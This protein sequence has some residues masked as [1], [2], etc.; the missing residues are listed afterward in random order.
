MEML[1]EMGTRLGEIETGMDV[2]G[3]I[4]DSNAQAYWI[5]AKLESYG[6]EAWKEGKSGIAYITTSKRHNTLKYLFAHWTGLIHEWW[7]R[8]DVL[9]DAEHRYYIPGACVETMMYGNERPNAKECSEEMK[10]MFRERHERRH[11]K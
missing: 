5:L 1:T 3:A 2:Y 9:W 6:I 4:F 11:K 10:R 7:F 8:F